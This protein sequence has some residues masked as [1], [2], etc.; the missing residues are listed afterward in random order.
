MKKKNVATIMASTMAMASVMPVFAAE[1]TVNTITI[2]VRTANGEKMSVENG[3]VVKTKIEG[4]SVILAKHA[5]DT[6]VAEIEKMSKETYEAIEDGKVVVKN[7]YD[8]KIDEEASVYKYSVDSE[9]NFVDNKVVVVVKNNQT[10]EVTN[11]E[12][13]GIKEY[14]LDHGFGQELP[15]KN[16][17]INLA[18]KNHYAK[19]TKVQYELEK[20]A[21]KLIVNK[22]K[23]T[24]ESGMGY[25]LKLVVT[26]NDGTTIANITIKNVQALNKD[27]YVSLPVNGD[28]TGHWAEKTVLTAMFDKWVDASTSFRPEDSITRAEFVK[29]VNRAFG[30]DLTIVDKSMNTE[31]ADVKAENWYY[32][33]VKAAARAGYI[34]GYEDG[35]F[36]PDQPIT[37]QEAAKIIA[38]LRNG[39][40]VEIVEADVNGNDVEK[41]T[42]TKFNDDA[43]IAVWADESVEY[44]TNEGIIKGYDGNVFKPQNNI[45]RAEAVEMMARAVK[46]IIN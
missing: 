46:N 7:K 35:T 39:A 34:N 15:V 45:K 24:H 38:K 27:E 40:D 44:L 13:V 19:M 25:D 31:F 17:T 36:R 1:E 22:E 32:A 3:N 20:D 41:D 8:V 14:D 29:I 43:D 10:E 4:D 18:N 28:I 11:Y 33:D 21:D 16:V 23:E 42:K 6:K 37:R 12:F 26:L 2:D 30:I 9:G 5:M